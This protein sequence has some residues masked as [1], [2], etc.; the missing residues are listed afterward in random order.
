MASDNLASAQH[1][2]EYT[3][4]T[5]AIDLKAEGQ[6]VLGANQDGLCRRIVVQS[7]SGA[8]TITLKA[9]HGTQDAITVA[10]GSVLD[11]AAKEITSVSGVTRVT[12]YW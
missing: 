1:W 2:R 8:A 3:T 4:F 9:H 10:A 7:V 5:S 12:V 11:V 6:S